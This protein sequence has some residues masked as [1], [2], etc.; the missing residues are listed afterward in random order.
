MSNIKTYPVYY[1]DKPEPFSNLKEFT[2]SAK[3][4]PNGEIF[5]R[6]VWV[7]NE[8]DFYKLLAHWN[9]SSDKWKYTAIVFT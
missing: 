3:Y 2:Y 5:H 4:L 7:H 1:L 6:S 9:W 8:N